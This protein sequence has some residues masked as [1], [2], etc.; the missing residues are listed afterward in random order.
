MKIFITGATGFIGAH[1]ALEL[2]NAG[3]ELRMLVRNKASAEDYF[4]KQGH[5]VN[6]F[7]VADMQD[8]EAI[9]NGLQGCDAVLHAAAMVSLNPKQ[10]KQVYQNNINS[11][12]AVLGSAFEMGIGN[13]VYVSSLAALFHGGTSTEIQE[14]TEQTPLGNPK[15]A[16]LKSKR[17]C[18]VQVR[19]LKEQGAP[20]QITY[21]SGVFGPE[22]PK[23][24]ESNHA[25]ITFLSTM[26][27]RT[28]SGIQCV[29]VRDVAKVHLHLLE[30]GVEAGDDGRYIVAGHYYSWAEFHQLL[31]QVTD[32]KIFS[33][34]I[35]GPLFR[36][37]GSVMDVAKRVYPIDIPIT[38]ESMNIVTNWTP[39]NS[40]KVL[41]KTA[42]QFRSG[43]DTFG[44]TISWLVKAGHLNPLFAGKALQ[45]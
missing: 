14:I 27:P 45:G 25:L 16:Y 31:Q 21:P 43:S 1:T 8:K 17:D 12:D 37:M 10:A 15:E 18:E 13:I 6:D 5:Q 44:D 35:P 26:T 22:D 36:F 39:A 41:E 3:H 19:K 34:V 7:V 32:R 30:K 20:I 23:L 38:S 29:D 2:L 11:I 9:Q 33:P 42:L 28:S 40:G 24:N 4:A